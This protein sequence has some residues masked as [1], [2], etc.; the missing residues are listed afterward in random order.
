MY[1]KDPIVVGQIYHIYS[2]GV[3]KGPI[4][5]E[6]AD[7][8]RFLQGLVLFNDVQSAANILWRLERGRG[9]LTMNVLKEYVF[10]G[11]AKR[12]PLV[13]ILAY[14]V[15]GNHYHL[16]VEEIREG[17]ITQFMRKLGTGYARYFNNKY[18]RVG[19]LFQSRFKNVLVDEERFLL[20]L[21]VYINVLNPAEFVEENW[22]EKGIG[23]PEKVL[24]YSEKYPWSSHQ[25]Y[26]GLR[27]SIILE[28]GVLKELLS[29]PKAYSD[30]VRMVLDDKKYQDITHLTLES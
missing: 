15:M 18:E 19:P 26:L 17:G 16:L 27:N 7:R 9:R 4:C 20:Y 2:R 30:L 10:S 24:R 25:D 11:K 12:E 14:C 1:R 6:E 3:A 5:K 28:K 23:N 22:K 8:W 13:R 29:T 21:L